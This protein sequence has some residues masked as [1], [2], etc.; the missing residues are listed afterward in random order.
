MNSRNFKPGD[1]VVYRK[2]KHSSHPGPRAQLVTPSKHGEDYT[3]CVDKFWLVIDARGDQVTVL[4]RG[5]KQHVVDAAD[6]NLR[7]AGWWDLLVNRLRFPSA[8]KTGS[9]T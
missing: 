2:P 7:H 9:T 1:R 8:E 3:Y 6:C 4:T 5:G